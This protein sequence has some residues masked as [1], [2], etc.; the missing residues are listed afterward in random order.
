MTTL[1]EEAIEQL[2][3]LPEEE[4]D[5]AA[6][7]VFAFV[8]SEERQYRLPLRRIA[9]VGRFSAPFK[10]AALGLQWPKS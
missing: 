7:M 1:L 3:A 2:R 6:E 8:S 4:Q 5:G 10:S 9:Q